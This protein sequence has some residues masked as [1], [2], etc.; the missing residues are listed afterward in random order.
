MG[1]GLEGQERLDG[2]IETERDD[3]KVQTLRYHPSRQSGKAKVNSRS[4][5][6]R[7]RPRFC[8][9]NG[10]VNSLT[11]SLRYVY[12]APHGAK[13]C[14]RFAHIGQWNPKVLRP[15]HQNSL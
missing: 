5:Q 12:K 7:R 10:I 9:M 3:N 6:D 14:T 15:R 1:H 13:S 4:D 8:H 2:L 11:T